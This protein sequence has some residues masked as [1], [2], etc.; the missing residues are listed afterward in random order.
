MGDKNVRIKR[1]NVE[2]LLQDLIK[3]AEYINSHPSKKDFPYTVKRLWVYG[4]YVNSEK[5]HLGDIDIFYELE[6]RWDDTITAANY[7][8]KKNHPSSLPYGGGTLGYLAYPEVLTVKFLRNKH[9][10]FSFLNFNTLPNFKP[11]PT[12]EM[13]YKLIYKH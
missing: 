8:I 2:A 11:D 9:K 3:Q 10:A 13:V 7:F 5:T 1:E 6:N 4:S 12:K